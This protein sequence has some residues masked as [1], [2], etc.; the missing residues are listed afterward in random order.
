MK[1]SI[2]ASIAVAI[3]ISALKEVPVKQ[4]YAMTGSLSVRGEVRQ[5]AEYSAIAAIEAGIK[6][7]VVSQI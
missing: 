6:Q 4:E 7:V 5:S 1:A 2:S 3:I